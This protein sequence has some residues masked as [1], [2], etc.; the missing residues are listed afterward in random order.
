MGHIDTCLDSLR[1]LIRAG[2]MNGLQMAEKAIEEY[3]AAVRADPNLPESRLR[4]AEDLR[5]S[6]QLAASADQYEA[7]VK[8]DPTIVEAW[9]GGAH[10][11]I[12][13]KRKDQA[14]DWLARARRLYPAR[15]ELAQMQAGLK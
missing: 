13:L 14:I 9:I 2:D 12:D 7:A 5:G 11:L 1:R 4:L 3:R 15:P 8:L 6:G 10:A